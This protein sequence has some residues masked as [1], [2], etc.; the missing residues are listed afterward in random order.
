MVSVV[1]IG[2]AVLSLW[3]FDKTV[4][5]AVTL[6]LIM[7]FSIPAL[8]IKKNTVFL[9]WLIVFFFLYTWLGCRSLFSENW[10]VSVPH[11]INL[12]IVMIPAL[13]LALTLDGRSI[14]VLI[15]SFILGGLLLAV[16]IIYG[17]L[18][19]GGDWRTYYN[20][21]S[22]LFVGFYLSAASSATL[23]EF[24][25]A[26]KK[27]K[28]LFIVLVITTLGVGLSLSR[29]ALFSSVAVIC[30][31]LFVWIKDVYGRVSTVR[32][33]YVIV[34]IIV[35]F[36]IVFILPEK[37]AEGLKEIFSNDADAILRTGY[38]LDLFAGYFPM[39]I[40]APLCG[41]G[42]GAWSPLHS[43]YQFSGYFLINPGHPHNLF[44]QLLIDGGLVALALGC[45]IF[46]FPPVL[47]IR[48]IYR[49]MKLVNFNVLR[50]HASVTALYMV[51]LI[52]HLKSHELYTSFS[53]VFASG[54]MVGLIKE[55]FHK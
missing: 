8:N 6:V 41:H 33:S 44:L 27:S 20:V 13:L 30:A 42:A 18:R 32:F 55:T 11:L 1:W 3:T 26:E 36:A 4:F 15:L 35:F 25:F 2:Q 28:V 48:I 7:L 31:L 9:S 38:R 51:F 45:F 17:A 46:L 22:Y 14:D 49:N 23:A 37:T 34:F 19:G 39:V 16:L 10:L 29:T 40:D 43:S 53:L 21:D 50:R 12:A 54:V 24:L 47:S 52:E 5:Y